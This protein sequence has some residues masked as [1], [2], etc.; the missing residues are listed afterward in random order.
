MSALAEDGQNIRM[1]NSIWLISLYIYITSV[2]HDICG[3]RYLDACISKG[4]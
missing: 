3:A 1:M 2:S 4:K